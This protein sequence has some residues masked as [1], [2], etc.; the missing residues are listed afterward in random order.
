MWKK[1]SQFIKY[2]FTFILICISAFLIAKMNVLNQPPLTCVTLNC[3]G[4]KSKVGYLKQLCDNVDVICLQETWLLEHDLGILNNIHPDFTAFS[5]SG[6]DSGAGILVGRPFGGVSILW[7]NKL[8]CKILNYDDRRMLGLM[9]EKFH[10][11]TSIYFSQYVRV[12][13]GTLYQ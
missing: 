10:L 5:I 6:V 13:Y 12:W 2:T 3:E 8:P 1:I 7:R 11:N 9:L 4:V